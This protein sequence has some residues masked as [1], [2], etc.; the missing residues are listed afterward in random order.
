MFDL[1]TKGHECVLFANP[2]AAISSHLC[3]KSGQKNERNHHSCIQIEEAE[4][5]G[6]KNL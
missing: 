2:K 4:K 6:S 5:K 1:F 3:E